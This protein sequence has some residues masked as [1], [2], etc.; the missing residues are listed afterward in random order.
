MELWVIEAP[1][2][3]KT[4]E[5]ILARLG[6]NARVQATRGHLLTMP[7]SL[8]QVGIDRKLYEFARTPRDINVLQR[9]RD[10][11]AAADHL[12]IAT[13]ADQEGDVI[14][15]DVCEVCA[16]LH[17][18]PARVR[19]RGMDDESIRQA[20]REATSVSKEDAIPGRTR[21]LIDR[22]IGATF[23]GDGVAV[24]RVGTAIL[25]LVA[26]T[27]LS[28]YRMRLSAPA[29]DGGRPFLAEHPVIAPLTREVAT[30]L[31]ALALPALPVSGF[32]PQHTPPAHTGQ[33]LLRAAEQLDV[34]VG[35]VSDAMQRNYEAGK[36]S[37][38]RSGSPAMSQAARDRVKEM[39]RKAGFTFDADLLPKKV[40]AKKDIHDAP[41]PIGPVALDHNPQRLG[42]DEGVRTFV[43][44][45]LVKPGQKHRAEK[46]MTEGLRRFLLKE[47]FSQE[48]ADLV[49]DLDWR[50]EMGPRYPGQQSWAASEIVE[51]R[52]DAVILEAILAANLGRPSTWAS[53]VENFLKRG[54][55]DD[56]LRLTQKGRQWIAASPP[57]LLDPALSVAI[58]A[59]CERVSPSPMADSNREPHEVLAERIMSVMPAEIRGRVTALIAETEPRPR[60]DALA[61]LPPSQ[62]PSA[63]DLS[64]LTEE[65]VKSAPAAPRPP[66]HMFD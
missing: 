11:A 62:E 7:E 21:A 1:G 6:I 12:V 29:A 46:A 8:A 45:E 37:Y 55:V 22:L 14:A 38:P 56:E 51:R 15:W 63:L 48:V 40:D 57:A 20:I 42:Q 54:L 58:E 36:M 23:S 43:A 3:A 65:S 47:G 32:I 4:L 16:D 60:L 10:E 44:R 27:P 64:F 28:V 18:S 59:A 31:T 33:I 34:S 17:P 66:D 26:K 5:E 2:K 25:G 61:A 53:H 49:A 13:D 39:V 19:L 9:L 50:R 35:E 30:R 52:P 41:H 24:G